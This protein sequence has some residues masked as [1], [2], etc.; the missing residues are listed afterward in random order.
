MRNPKISSWFERKTRS[1]K[2][3]EMNKIKDYLVNI[4]GKNVVVHQAKVAAKL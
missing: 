4:P 3:F 1:R 2:L